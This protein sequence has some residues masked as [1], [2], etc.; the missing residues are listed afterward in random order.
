MELRTRARD[1]RGMVPRLGRTTTLALMHVLIVAS[2]ASAQSV[3]TPITLRASTTLAASAEAIA[4][5]AAARAHRPVVVGAPLEA[6]LDDPAQAPDL[7]TSVLG[8][9]HHGDRIAV[10]GTAPSGRRHVSEL[11]AG[12]T[13]AANVRAIVIAIA[14]LL[15]DLATDTAHIPP[16]EREHV[17]EIDLPPLD[18]NALEDLGSP[19][20]PLRFEPG[21]V[22]ELR[23]RIGYATQR[24]QGVLATGLATGACFGTWWCVLL[25]VDAMA[26][27]EVHVLGAGT[28]RYQATTLGI[29]GRFLPLEAGPVRGGVGVDATLRVGELWT[30]VPAYS[31]TSVSGGLRF[32]AELTV[33]LGGPLWLA[34]EGGADV[35]FNAVRFF[36]GPDTVLQEDVLLPWIALGLRL[37]PL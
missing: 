4:S 1:R 36:R 27:E 9:A 34:I 6:E 21:F 31:F 8:V 24:D 12:A 10:F 19:F 11:G 18:G 26:P 32:V 29:G 2:H 35:G 25:D 23:E 15:E 28:L 13:D 16:V 14:L 7:G 17:V 20:T 37:G 33:H 22:I 3:D 30:D 5:R